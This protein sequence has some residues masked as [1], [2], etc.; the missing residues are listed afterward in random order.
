MN[1]IIIAL[2]LLYPSISLAFWSTQT[3]VGSEQVKIEV[4]RTYD[5]GV[6]A[7]FGGHKFFSNYNCIYTP[8]TN[9]DLTLTIQGRKIKALA[10]CGDED[11]KP[12]ISSYFEK[13]NT[14]VINALKNNSAIY[15][16]GATLNSYSFKKAYEEESNLHYAALRLLESKKNVENNTI[17]NLRKVINQ[18]SRE[19]KNS[20]NIVSQL[21][22]EVENLKNKNESNDNYFLVF[23]IIAVMTLS[24]RSLNKGKNQIELSSLKKKLKEKNDEIDS[25]SKVLSDASQIIIQLESSRENSELLDKANATIRKAN[26]RI[27]E[28]KTQIETLK[29]ELS[30]SQTNKGP[31]DGLSHLDILGF[32]SK[33]DRKAVKARYLKLSSIY[34]PD[35]GGCDSMMQRINCAYN[36]LK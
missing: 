34:H 30:Q 33:P 36:A 17:L 3:G 10:S 15:V 8:H 19:I 27:S 32:V 26:V 11:S 2:I 9:Y 28:L 7:V 25:L 31:E 18:Q 6:H 1:R 16:E 13:D 35:K 21:H 12:E 24:I 14:F 5:K 22:D 4:K 29:A 23:V 20:R